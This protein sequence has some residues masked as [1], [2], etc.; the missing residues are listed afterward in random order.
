MRKSGSMKQQF[1]MYKRQV[2]ELQNKLYDET[3]R[4]DKS[5]FEA[6]RAVDKMATLQREK[7]VK[8]H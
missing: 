3:K 8:R 6:K 4:A 7:E 2:H 5:D 1:D